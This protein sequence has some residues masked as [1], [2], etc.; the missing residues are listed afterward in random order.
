MSLPLVKKMIPDSLRAYLDL[1]RDYYDS[2][3]MLLVHVS[4]YIK[5]T[6]GVRC[7]KRYVFNMM[8]KNKDI[9]RTSVMNKI[10]KYN[11]LNH[12]LDTIDNKSYVSG[13]REYTFFID[14]NATCFY[15]DIGYITCVKE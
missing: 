6:Y 13:D 12:F 1:Q 10:A 14:R 7:G 4:E 3:Y 9:S 2:P 8:E 15:I 11:S 5:Q